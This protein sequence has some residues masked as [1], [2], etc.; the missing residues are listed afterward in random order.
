MKREDVRFASGNDECAAWLYRPEGDASSFPCVVMASGL[1]CVRDQGLDAFA[2]RFAAAGFAALAFDY[3]Y[4]GDSGGEPRSLLS[5]AR[6]RQDW[7]AAVAFVGAEDGVDASRV[8][9]W[10]FS[11]GGAHV[12]ALSVVEPGIAAAICVAPVVDGARSLLHIGGPAHVARLWIAGLRDGLR[13]LRRAEPYRI[14]A[15]GPPGSLAALN[16]PDSVPGFESVT[17]QGSSWG[18]EI[19]ARVA[20][21]P[22]YRLAGKARRIPCPVLYCLVEDDDVNPPALGRRA[23]GAAPLGELSLF[24]GGHF[25]PFRGETFERMATAQVE[26]LTRHLR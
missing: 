18:N 12:Q 11:L 21:A 9:L 2:R 23:A 7:R 26:F 6:Q 13:A 17:P 8:V 19:C 3:R 14:A 10:G 24:P 16:S 22:P 4:F 1:S 5:A 15:A 20:L 25:D